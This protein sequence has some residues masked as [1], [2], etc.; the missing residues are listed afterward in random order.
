MAIIITRET[1]ISKVL[2]CCPGAI[3]IFNQF[4]MECYI[5]CGSAQETLEEG[6]LMHGVDVD[7]IVAQL[8]QFEET[9]A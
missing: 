6:A 9:N 1:P 3:E 7:L 2:E 5:C 4:N 8:N